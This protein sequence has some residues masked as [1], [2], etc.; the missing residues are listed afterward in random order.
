MGGKGE[1]GIKNESQGSGLSNWADMFLFTALKILQRGACW[2]II[3][4]NQ[5]LCFECSIFQMSLE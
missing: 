1:T 3:D 4:G 2:E 5:E